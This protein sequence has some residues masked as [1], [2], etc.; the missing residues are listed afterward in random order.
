MKLAIV[1]L[2]AVLVLPAAYAAQSAGTASVWS[3]IIA[4]VQALV[5]DLANAIAPTTSTSTVTSVNTTS[6]STTTKPTTST[7]FLT[8]SVST[9]STTSTTTT[10]STTTSI[11][12][13]QPPS[14]QSTEFLRPNETESCPPVAVYLVDV[15]T[16]NQ[17]YEIANAIVDIYDSNALVYANQS[18][19]QNTT[20]PYLFQLDNGAHLLQI[21]A[22]EV[23]YAYYPT[24]RYANLTLKYT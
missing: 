7:S 6:A 20:S 9:T 21:Y 2:I 17:Q 12:P 16:G 24:G 10:S 4:I 8:T 23:H 22:Y 11:S 5:R 15:G 19:L 14:C 3:E 1:F 13:S 18:L